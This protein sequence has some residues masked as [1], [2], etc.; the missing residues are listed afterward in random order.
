[1]FIL[2]LYCII[3]IYM[4]FNNPCPELTDPW[5]LAPSMLHRGPASFFCTLSVS[6]KLH[7]TLAQLVL[8]LNSHHLPVF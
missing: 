4:Y 6:T 5:L 7:M 3:Y 1:M 8:Q 2:Y